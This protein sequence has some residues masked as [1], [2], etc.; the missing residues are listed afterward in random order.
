MNVVEE[1][2]LRVIREQAAV[3]LDLD[4]GSTTVR[5]ALKVELCVNTVRLADNRCGSNELRLL[6]AVVSGRDGG[7]KAQ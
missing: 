7:R 2:S 4:E 5:V 6:H 1:W 3:D